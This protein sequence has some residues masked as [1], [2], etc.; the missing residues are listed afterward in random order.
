MLASWP[1]SRTGSATRRSSR[2]DHARQILAPECITWVPGTP[3]R[4]DPRREFAVMFDDGRG[5]EDRIYRLRTGYAWSQ[6][7]RSRG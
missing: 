4:G 3:E 7:P 1:S 2:S 5:M 6:A